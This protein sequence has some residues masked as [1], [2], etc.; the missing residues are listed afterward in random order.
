MMD[1]GGAEAEA[2]MAA[3]RARRRPV[4]LQTGAGFAPGSR[5]AQDRLCG[6][7]AGAPMPMAPPVP[8]AD[9]TGERE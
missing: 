7:P 8:L 6:P 5:I 9:A 4:R 3:G 1:D 2:M